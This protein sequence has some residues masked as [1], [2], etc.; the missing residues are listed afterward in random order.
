MILD[1]ARRVAAHA[2]RAR[3][4]ACAV[5]RELLAELVEL[6]R[7]IMVNLRDDVVREW[8]EPADHWVV[9][10]DAT[11]ADIRIV[12]MARTEAIRWLISSSR[13]LEADEIAEPPASGFHVVAGNVAVLEVFTVPEP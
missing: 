1:F 6:N 5:D 9:L 11:H 7:S 8:N 4:H 12:V 13:A 3:E 10:L 2:I